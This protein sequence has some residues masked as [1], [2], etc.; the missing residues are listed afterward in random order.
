MAQGA[1]VSAET[2]EEALQKARALFH[3]REYQ[4]DKF[5]LVETVN[6]GME[7]HEGAICRARG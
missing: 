4:H 6:Y 5:V 2:E 7:G 1:E 3:E